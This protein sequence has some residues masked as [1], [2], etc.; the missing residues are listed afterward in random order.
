MIPENALVPSQSM[1]V[2]ALHSVMHICN[3]VICAEYKEHCIAAEALAQDL[4]S[5]AWR[6]YDNYERDLIQ[7]GW[8]LVF[9]DYPP[10]SEQDSRVVLGTK[11]YKLTCS[12]FRNWRTRLKSYNE[13]V[14][15]CI[16]CNKELNIALKQ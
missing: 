9:E 6:N 2:Q 11:N 8:T 12:M 15:R 7:L 16:T 4:E 5:D 3:C 1:G 10:D 13:L 14:M